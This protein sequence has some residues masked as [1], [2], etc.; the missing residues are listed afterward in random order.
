MPPGPWRFQGRP[1]PALGTVLRSRGSGE[2]W[3]T[4]I[5]RYWK[6]KIKGQPRGKA[7]GLEMAEAG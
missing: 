3:H 1:A 6:G 7:E 2:R 5:R 4:G